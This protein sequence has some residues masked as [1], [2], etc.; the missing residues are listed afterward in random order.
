MS[1]SLSRI[2]AVIAALALA[3]ALIAMSQ[4]HVLAS[5]SH[6]HVGDEVVKTVSAGSVAPGNIHGQ[7]GDE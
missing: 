2:G 3:I 4:T 5:A 7:P 6:G 1:I